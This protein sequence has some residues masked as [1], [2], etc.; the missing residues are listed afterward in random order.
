MLEDTLNLPVC[1][2]FLIHFAIMCLEALFITMV[3]VLVQF[4]THLITITFTRFP[5]ICQTFCLYS[6]ECQ[7]SLK[8]FRSYA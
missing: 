1:G 7:E 8:K 2:L 5:T 6:A 3:N 4:T